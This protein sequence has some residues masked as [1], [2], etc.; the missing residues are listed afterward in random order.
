MSFQCARPGPVEYKEGPVTARPIIFFDPPSLGAVYAAM[1]KLTRSRHDGVIVKLNASLK[2]GFEFFLSVMVFRF[3]MVF[4]FIIM[5][6]LTYG[7]E[8]RSRDVVKLSQT[9]HVATPVRLCSIG[10]QKKFK[11]FTSK[12]DHFQISPAASPEMYH[13]TV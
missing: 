5:D 2:T 8:K 11:P 4:P 10:S 7:S 9:S 1:T 13:H 12:S 6:T 3:L